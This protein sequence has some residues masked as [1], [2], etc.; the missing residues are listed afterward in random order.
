MGHTD[1]IHDTGQAG[2]KDSFAIHN[3][4]FATLYGCLQDRYRDQW[5]MIADAT[6]LAETWKRTMLRYKI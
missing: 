6:T 4:I 5:L 3:V 2:K 1:R